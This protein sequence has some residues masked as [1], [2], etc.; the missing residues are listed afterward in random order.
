MIVGET[1]SVTTYDVKLY[2]D[3]APNDL[4]LVFKFEHIFID[5]QEG[6]KLMKTTSFSLF[7]F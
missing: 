2:S 6:S 7:L 5:E 1:W 4:T 3:P